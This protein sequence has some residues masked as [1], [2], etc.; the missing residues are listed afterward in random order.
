LRRQALEWIKANESDPLVAETIVK[1]RALYTPTVPSVAGARPV[2]SAR[3]AWELRHISGLDP[4]KV[5]AARLAVEMAGRVDLLSGNT[6]KLAQTA[7]LIHRMATRTRR[8][9]DRGDGLVAMHVYPHNQ[10]IGL[11]Y[12]GR[13]VDVACSSLLERLQPFMA[14][15]QRL[16]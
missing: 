10:G 3:A 9:W 16:P 2:D 14:T 1:V 8:S 4:R 11:R 6:F 13:A 7:K 12:I 15:G 5:M